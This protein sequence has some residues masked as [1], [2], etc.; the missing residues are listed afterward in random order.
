MPPPQGMSQDG[1]PV[2]QTLR[3]VQ[4]KD[5]LGVEQISTVRHKVFLGRRAGGGGSRTVP[6]ALRVRVDKEVHAR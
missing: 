1:V 2:L 6:P 3:R 5:G 4:A